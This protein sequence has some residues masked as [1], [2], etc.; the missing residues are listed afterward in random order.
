M[1][2]TCRVMDISNTVV[3]TTQHHIFCLSSLHS[4]LRRPPYCRSWVHPITHCDV[5]QYQYE[6]G[7]MGLGLKTNTILHHSEVCPH[8]CPTPIQGIPSM[9]MAFESTLISAC[10]SQQVDTL[11][12]GGA[13]CQ[14]RFAKQ[15]NI[16][17]AGILHCSKLSRPKRVHLNYYSLLKSKCCSEYDTKLSITGRKRHCSCILRWLAKDVQ[18]HLV[19]QLATPTLS[20]SRPLPSSP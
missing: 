20:A 2:V 5:V 6:E 9:Y 4:L 15:W 16:F 17:R 19:L 13:S 10:M 1:D 12:K 14:A 3:L 7:D 11:A 8:A 18:A